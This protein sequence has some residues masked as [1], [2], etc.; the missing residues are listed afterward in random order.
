VIQ[1]EIPHMQEGLKI[2]KAKIPVEME[3]VVAVLIA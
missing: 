2:P 3:I 1:V